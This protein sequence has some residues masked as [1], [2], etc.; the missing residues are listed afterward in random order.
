MFRERVARTL[1]GVAMLVVLLIVAMALVAM[2]I[3]NIA[4][5]TG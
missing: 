4:A 3:F 1:P 2:F 5:D